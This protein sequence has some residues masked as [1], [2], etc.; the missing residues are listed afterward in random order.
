MTA[1]IILKWGRL[2]LATLK[3]TP[4]AR[5]ARVRIA[6]GKQ[7]LTA[8]VDYADGALLLRFSP[9]LML[10]AGETLQASME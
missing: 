10:G 3:L 7:V 9:P 2:R 6:R 4:P 5:P 8:G 1:E